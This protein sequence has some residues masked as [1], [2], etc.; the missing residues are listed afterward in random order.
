[1]LNRRKNSRGLSF[2]DSGFSKEKSPLISCLMTFS[3]FTK[4]YCSFT[5]FSFFNTVITKS[6][7]AI[8]I[9]LSITGLLTTGVIVP[10]CLLCHFLLIFCEIA[11]L[12][13]ILLEN[14]CSKKIKNP[15][16]KG[17]GILLLHTNFP[18][19]IN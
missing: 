15:L 6:S 1:M 14:N 8:L 13:G 17:K 5:S 2:L 18:A 19:K 12:Y 11:F 9:S 3:I 10:A 4:T 16:P 7:L